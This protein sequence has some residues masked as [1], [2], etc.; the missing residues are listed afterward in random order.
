MPNAVLACAA[1]TDIRAAETIALLADRTCKEGKA[2]AYVCQNFACQAPVT[3]PEELAC[4][5]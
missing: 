1:P 3:L 4:L 2:T 5:L